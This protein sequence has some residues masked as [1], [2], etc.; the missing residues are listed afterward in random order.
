MA[1]T[2]RLTHRYWSTIQVV[3]VAVL[4][5]GAERPKKQQLTHRYRAHSENPISVGQATG[6]SHALQ[7]HDPRRHTCMLKNL[8][9]EKY[10]WAEE[11]K[12]ENN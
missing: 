9:K 1:Q 11:A 4:G 10:G 5:G 2:G 3:L 12:I 6:L 7:C 8:K